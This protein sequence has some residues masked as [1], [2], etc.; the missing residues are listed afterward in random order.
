MLANNWTDR[1]AGPVASLRLFFRSPVDD[2]ALD[3]DANGTESEDGA[4][5]NW[6]FGTQLNSLFSYVTNSAKGAYIPLVHFTAC[7]QS[8][9]RNPR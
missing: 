7:K 5:N 9:T 4:Q 3:C 8:D 1:A 2:P 6:E